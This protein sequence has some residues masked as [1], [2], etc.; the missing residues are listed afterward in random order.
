MNSVFGNNEFTHISSR[1]KILFFLESLAG[2][3]AENVLTTLVENIDKT[4]FDV[5]VCTVVDTGVY[6][7]RVRRCVN[8]CSIIEESNSLLGRLKYKLIYSILPPRLVYR[9]F[10]PK[11][12]DV[13]IAFIEG[14]ATRI[15]SASTNKHSR[16][17][18]WV[19]TDLV[20]NHWTDI[21]YRSRS[22]ESEAY[23]KF[24]DVV[25]VSENVS[26][27]MLSI[28]PSLQNLRVIYNP[29]D[30]V[31]IREKAEESVADSKFIEGQIKLVSVGRLVSQK[32]YDR[33]LPILKRLH[34]EGY[35]FV[36]NILG[37]GPDRSELERYI[38]ANE[39]ESYVSLMGFTSNPYPY[40][41]ASDLFVCSS[42][43][44]GYSTAV[45]E[46]LILGVPVI[47][48]LCSGMEELLGNGEFGIIVD[49]DDDALLDGLKRLLSDATLI[50]SYRMKSQIRGK[51]F[52][53]E[54]QIRR[55]E[56][57][58]YQD[59]ALMHEEEIIVCD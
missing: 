54:R 23:A 58:L 31:S 9:L 11:G 57:F 50:Q 39:M 10:V 38:T 2:G 42:R 44:E 49:N 32:G 47:T 13:E 29:V 25:C 45:T 27:S 41:K 43:S 21:A 16:K 48:T 12:Y 33:L 19:H 5:T 18:A 53:L 30:D 56:G 59:K 22:E 55:I 36:M 35:S 7:D 24:D 51:D 40:I 37:E 15:I 3:G 8:Y 46:A 28:N 17:I 34:D 26:N 4:R 52:S 14:Y 20:N 6:R 1:R